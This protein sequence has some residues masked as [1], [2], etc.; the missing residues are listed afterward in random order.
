MKSVIINR[1]LPVSVIIGIIL[2]TFNQLLNSFYQQEE[3]LGLG[4]VFV[5]GSDYIFLIFKQDIFKAFL[6]EGRILS[7]I[8]NYFFFKVFPFNSTPLSLFA[9]LIHAINSILV[10]Y[11]INILLKRTLPAL[12]GALF[13]SV[14]AVAQSA[15]TWGSAISTLP[16]T[17]AILLS[18]L[19]F[20]K[21]INFFE[22][23]KIK[24]KWLYISFFILYLSL[25]FKQV[26]IFLFPLYFFIAKTYSLKKWDI[27]EILLSNWKRYLFPLGVFLVVVLV[28]LI[29]YKSKTA[30]DV[31]FLTGS[32]TEFFQTLIVRTLL[33]SLTSI[34][35]LFIPPE[36]FLSFSRYITNILYPFFPPEHFILIAQTVVLDLLSAVASAIILVLIYRLSKS[37]DFSKKIIIWFFVIFALCSFLPY[38][39][40]SRSFS[41]LDSR[42][43]YLGV[44]GAAFI[45]SWIVQSISK[46]S[47][48]V[49]WLLY[50][51]VVLFIFTHSYIVKA[52]IDQQV[53]V[54]Q[55]R[56]DFLLQLSAIKPQLE[57]NKNIFYITGDSDFYLPGHKVPFQNGVGHTLAVWYYASGNIP[58]ELIKSGDLFE[59]GKQGYFEYG[60]KGFGYFSD[61]D[62]LKETIKDHYLEDNSIIM[63]YYDAEKEGLRELSKEN[64]QSLIMEK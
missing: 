43:Y 32:S 52:N 26:G 8:I 53:S 63:L 1:I 21:S 55:E 44:I 51:L 15:I 27:K 10:F 61:L 3:W 5:Y 13:F 54:S 12:M 17:T 48:P 2:L 59:I 4:N 16:A 31:L 40:I 29:T 9:L 35:Q 60:E 19:F 64:L 37:L 41:Y 20:F 42:Y 23:G 11:L 34:S 62:K 50:V 39:L 45:L 24:L 56:K 18:L 49:S 36:Q 22:E 14:N 46:L 38:V 47:K 25:L 33:Y 6:G 28:Y 30:P 57:N 58:K 7:S